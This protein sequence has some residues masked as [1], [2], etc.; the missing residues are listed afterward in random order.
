[1][2]ILLEVIT[3]IV[4]IVVLI[5]V[6]EL[7]HF[8]VAKLSGMRVDEFGIGYPPR[9]LTFG[10]IGETEYTLNWLP[11]GGFVRIYGEDGA[12]EEGKSSRAFN[13]K[14]RILQ[15]LTLIAGIVMNVLFAYVL[16]MICLSIG[17]EQVIT[18]AAQ[19]A[20]AKNIQVAI[21]EVVPGGPAA[22]AG[23][24]AGDVIESA[25]STSKTL[26]INY[27]GTM[28]GGYITL[29]GTDTD[30]NP[31]TFLIDRNG[32]MLS[33]TATPK[34]GSIPSAPTRPGFG[35]AIVNIGVIKTPLSQVPLLGLQ[36]IWNETSAT[37]VGLYDFFK[38]IVL[39]KADFSQVS[40]PIGIAGIV[41]QAAS[42]GIA[43]L[44]SLTA[45]ISI[46]LALINLIPIPALDG[47]RL[48]FV[49]IEAIIRRPIN[50]K[51]AERVNMV[52]FGLLL[53]LMVVVSA[54]DIWNLVK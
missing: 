50:P 37:G 35:V 29:I 5:L 15:A 6:H 46:N 38:S 4:V 48:L 53:L 49:I 2:H 52:G 19:E 11:F 51:I 28:P 9:A 27:D 39:F 3:L 24:M 42:N 21:A 16:I 1:M 26:G 12:V 25:T 34:V 30:L 41:G 22:Q 7:G 43:A 13:T 10:K 33:I 8:I 31:I 36:N 40:G 20:T 45:L 47:G 32:K 54:H 44:L 17:T 14:P 23:F 18:T